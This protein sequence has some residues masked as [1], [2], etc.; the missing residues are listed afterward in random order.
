MQLSP[1]IVPKPRFVREICVERFCAMSCS[2]AYRNRPPHGDY[3]ILVNVNKCGH[4]GA[5][6]AVCPTNSIELIESS[7]TLAETCVT[8]GTCVSICPLGALTAREEVT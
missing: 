1:E 5:C 6:V 7:L 3:V 2:H 4:C 8:C